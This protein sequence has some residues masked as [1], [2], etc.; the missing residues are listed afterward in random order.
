MTLFV[1]VIVACLAL[2]V[3]GALIYRNNA[4][5][6]DAAIKSIERAGATAESVGKTVVADA[7]KV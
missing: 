6:A 1:L 3:G 4:A 5:K 7:K 2:M